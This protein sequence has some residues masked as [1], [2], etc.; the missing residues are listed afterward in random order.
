MLRRFH[1]SDDDD[2]GKGSLGTRK[3]FGTAVKKKYVRS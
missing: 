1:E 2:K 3:H